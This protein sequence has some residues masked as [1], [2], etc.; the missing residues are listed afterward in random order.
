MRDVSRGLSI[1]Y[2][3]IFIAVLGTS[4]CTLGRNASNAGLTT[5]EGGTGQIEAGGHDGTDIT[6]RIANCSNEGRTLEGCS[7]QL[8]RLEQEGPRACLNH[9]FLHTPSPR[10]EFNQIA[11]AC[12]IPEDHDGVN[13]SP[14]NP[15]HASNSPITTNVYVDDTILFDQPLSLSQ[16]PCRTRLEL[17]QARIPGFEGFT[18]FTATARN[19]RVEFNASGS[20]FYAKFNRYIPRDIPPDS[21]ITVEN[22]ISCFY[23][24]SFAGPIP[25]LSPGS[26]GAPP[27][28]TSIANEQ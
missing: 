14:W 26:S 28:N 13:D 17:L 12:G 21:R 16:H 4:S 15:Q 2:L 20:K 18:R 11:E 5:F 24:G 9:L 27:V 7:N 23:Y 8:P 3:I 22:A 6:I 10:L 25:N 19:H 1:R